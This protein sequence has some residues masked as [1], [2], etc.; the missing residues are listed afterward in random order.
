MKVDH[1]LLA[2]PS[3]WTPVALLNSASS[4]WTLHFGSIDSVVCPCGPLD[5]VKNENQLHSA[6][7]SGVQV[8][9]IDIP[10]SYWE[11]CHIDE[12]LIP[13]LS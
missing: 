10:N 2:M 13:V 6:Q 3:F 11:R 8:Y 7:D 5:T 4:S 1:G 9:S 12:I